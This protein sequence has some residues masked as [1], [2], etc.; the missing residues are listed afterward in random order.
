MAE[1]LA[2]YTVVTV[3][4]FNYFSAISMHSLAF[5]VNI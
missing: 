3:L 2:V 1:S 4:Y 5:L